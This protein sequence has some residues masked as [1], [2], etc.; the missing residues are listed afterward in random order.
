MKKFSVLVI[1]MIVCIF[2]FA[3]CVNTPNSPSNLSN[4][5]VGYEFEVYPTV[6][7]NYKINDDFVVHIS[8]ISVTLVEKNEIKA[9]DTIE[10][11][12]SPYTTKLEVSGYT[13]VKHSG[14]KIYVYVYAGPTTNIVCNAT[15]SEDGTF[16][17]YKESS[18]LIKS[19][20]I[21]FNY[22]AI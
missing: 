2:C 6:E 1:L 18:A 5:K 10:G 11:K 8:D 9:N 19:D 14:T 21:Y 7:F 4:Y 17:A 12:Y 3:G 13:D 22:I 20:T 15:I 16:Y